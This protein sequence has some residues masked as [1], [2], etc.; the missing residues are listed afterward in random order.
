MDDPWDFVLQKVAG[1]NQRIIGEPVVGVCSSGA[2]DSMSSSSSL[3][4]VFSFVRSVAAAADAAT[5]DDDDEGLGTSTGG[6]AESSASAD[7]TDTGDGCGRRLDSQSSDSS[8][9]DYEAD[10]EDE[11]SEEEKDNE[12]KLDLEAPPSPRCAGTSKTAAVASAGLCDALAAGTTDDKAAIEQVHEFGEE[13]FIKRTWGCAAGISAN[14]SAQDRNCPTTVSTDDNEAAGGTGNNAA[15]AESSGLAREKKP[16]SRQR[17]RPPPQ[18]RIAESRAKIAAADGS[19]AAAAD[20]YIAKYS[21]HSLR[22]LDALRRQFGLS[23]TLDFGDVYADPFLGAVVPHEL[24]REIVSGGCAGAAEEDERMM[25]AVVHARNDSR[26]ATGDGSG[27]CAADQTWRQRNGLRPTRQDAATC[28]ASTY[29]S[30]F[31][32]QLRNRVGCEAFGG[33]VPSPVAAAR[34]AGSEVIPIGGGCGGGGRACDR[35]RAVGSDGGRGGT[36]PVDTQEK[37]V[38]DIIS[39]QNYAREVQAYYKNDVETYEFF[40][41]YNRKYNKRVSN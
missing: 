7:T 12:M 41:K 2:V 9:V 23:A 20:E 18:Q 25:A 15:F 21:S 38:L 4:D 31:R 34:P 40:Y 19:A 8:A 28:Y 10:V 24:V 39:N 11:K 14:L 6:G 32:S 36:P 30:G 29:Q 27:G 5:S 1:I 3:E 37:F 35:G 16:P 17:R 33:V 22:L 13:E 26:P